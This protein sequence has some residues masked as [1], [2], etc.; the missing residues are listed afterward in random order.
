MSWGASTVGLVTQMIDCQSKTLGSTFDTILFR[1][2]VIPIVGW[3]KLLPTFGGRVASYSLEAEMEEEEGR[4][5]MTFELQE[6]E[7]A[8]KARDDEG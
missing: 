3:F 4:V 5:K 7:V 6:T 8:T 2:T 1:L